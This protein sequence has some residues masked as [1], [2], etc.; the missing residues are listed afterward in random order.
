MSV[1]ACTKP[2]HGFALLVAMWINTASDDKAGHDRALKSAA[3][4]FGSPFFFALYV[5]FGRSR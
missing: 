5:V 3:A 4:S 2:C 1:L